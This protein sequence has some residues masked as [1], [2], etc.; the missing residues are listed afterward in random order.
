MAL[1]I[2]I[3]RPGLDLSEKGRTETGETTSLDR[4]LFM[5]LLVFGNCYET[6]PLIDALETAGIQ[7]V[8]YEDVNDPYGVGLLTFDEDPGYFIETLRPFLRSAPFRSLTPKPE[9]TMMGRTYSIGYERDLEEVLLHR[10]RRHVCNPEWPWAIWYP[11]RRSGAFEK[12]SAEE[13][14]TILMEHGGIGRAYGRANYAH[15]VRLSCHGLDRLDNDFVTGLMGPALYPLSAI[16][17]HMRKTRQ[18]S[19]FLTRLGPFFVG[20]VAWQAPTEGV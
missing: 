5:Q 7:G 15:D 6:L 18:T 1:D 8:L 17:Q 12:L 20:R 3:A 9:F 10:P 11:L 16:V 14:R 4:R 13:Q 19:E 2:T